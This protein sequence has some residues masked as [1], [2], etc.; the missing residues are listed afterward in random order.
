MPVAV[1]LFPSLVAGFY[2]AYSLL[3]HAKQWS[4]LFL[5]EAKFRPH[6]FYALSHYWVSHSS[7]KLHEHQPLSPSNTIKHIDPLRL[8]PNNSQ[9]S[10]SP[11]SFLYSAFILLLLMFFGFGFPPI[12]YPQNTPDGCQSQ[13]VCRQKTKKSKK[14]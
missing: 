10:Y 4:H 5:S 7:T 14:R 6:L 9:D 8:C 13:G 3:S 1:C 2:P 11:Y 12:L